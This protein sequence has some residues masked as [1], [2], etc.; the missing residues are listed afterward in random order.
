M[1]T[2]RENAAAKPGVIAVMGM[3]AYYRWFSMVLYC[4]S[5]CCSLIFAI[6][7]TVV[8]G[9]SFVRLMQPS[10]TLTKAIE[11]T[12]TEIAEKERA[13]V[14]A[15]SEL[16]SGFDAIDRV[17]REIRDYGRA[18]T[19]ASTRLADARSSD[20]RLR[21]AANFVLSET[22][23]LD[24]PVNSLTA[25][26]S[27]IFVPEGNK[28]AA[29]FRDAYVLS[30]DN[31]LR[32]R[33]REIRAGRP[34]SFD[35]WADDYRKILPELFISERAPITFY[36]ASESLSEWV[37]RAEAICPDL[38]DAKSPVDAADR[39]RQW[40]QRDSLSNNTTTNPT[41]QSQREKINILVAHFALL[42]NLR[43]ILE[44]NF[45]LKLDSQPPVWL[46]SLPMKVETI[47]DPMAR[48]TMLDDLIQ[49]QLPLITTAIDQT[50]ND[51]VEQFRKIDPNDFGYHET[52][53]AFA[54]LD[55]ANQLGLLAR[56]LEKQRDNLTG[57][58]ILARQ[59]ARLPDQAAAVP[60]V[61]RARPDE[62]AALNNAEI[63]KLQQRV[64]ASLKRATT[65]QA[66][67][68]T[69]SRRN[70]LMTGPGPTVYVRQP[71]PSTVIV[72]QWNLPVIPPTVEQAPRPATS[73]D[74]NEPD[75][76]PSPPKSVSL[77]EVSD[78]GSTQKLWLKVEEAYFL[79]DVYDELRQLIPV[80]DGLGWESV[81][82]SEGSV[83]FNDDV[84]FG[85]YEAV[86]TDLVRQERQFSEATTSLSES[87]VAAGWLKLIS[88][89]EK[90]IADETLN[91]ATTEQKKADA[92]TKI[93]GERDA[94]GQKKKGLEIAQSAY[95][96]AVSKRVEYRDKLAAGGPATQQAYFSDSKMGAFFGVIVG[97]I[98]N[99][100][101]GLI[102][103]LA[104]RTQQTIGR[105]IDH[106]RSEAQ[107]ERALSLIRA[108]PLSEQRSAAEYRLI[109]GFAQSPAIPEGSPTNS[110]AIAAQPTS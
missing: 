21:E 47:S 95:D 85:L 52:S 100:I 28:D 63:L 50:R 19:T 77:Y 6:A 45:R 9:W 48:Q 88:D 30:F 89:A 87:V 27:V 35:S 104:T 10:E 12:E 18:A 96:H 38:K 33:I 43:R 5:V 59:G 7:G 82:D 54:L 71:M 55:L 11:L 51:L 105:E 98:V 61:N 108:M 81:A 74:K 15:K 34:V 91:L 17:D 36:R 37:Q 53:R 67:L 94:L 72:P 84:R 83:T 29:A 78:A 56:N 58:Q 49:N 106:A 65:T 25:P 90:T 14:I 60:A 101:S 46:G 2:T 16:Q 68:M 109:M 99:A 8:I 1:D 39:I 42:E 103:W 41:N 24:L 20:A 69:A 73:G 102:F 4:I 64:T 57:L 22:A 97:A 40:A 76:E 75:K 86:I 93:K 31:R 3:I 79:R 107:F 23:Q 92:E 66:M 13:L 62:P 26:A 110:S 80:V 70:Y 32:S 44:S